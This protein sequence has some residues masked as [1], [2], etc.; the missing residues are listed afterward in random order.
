LPTTSG[1]IVTTAGATELTT[2]GNLTFTGPGNRILGDFS[3]ATVANRVMF[4]TSTTNGNT[5]IH[6][7]PNGTGTSSSFEAST[8][9]IGSAASVAQLFSLTTDVRLAANVRDSGTFVPITMHTGGSERLRIDTSGNVGIGTTSTGSYD[10]KFIVS[11]NAALTST[12]NKLYLYYNSATNHANLSTSAGGDITFTTGTSSPTER[13]RI[14]TAGNL[15]VGTTANGGLTGNIVCPAIYN[16]TSANAANMGIDAAFGMFR[17]TSSIKYKTDV[18]DA[19]HGLTELLSLRPVTYKGKND[20]DAVFG[21]LI[22]EE[23]HE[24]GL[25]EFVQ[26]AEDGS[27]DSLAYGHMVS[28]CV[29]AIQELNAKVTALEAQLG[30][31]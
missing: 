1:T 16:R 28:L 20:G 5:N 9:P 13:M 12:G 6:A 24:A 23:V 19:V 29:K 15:L 4:Q 2:S 8:A 30:A 3:N 14:D 21:G 27:P 22:A 18:Q 17:S 11:G 10:S 26:Y 7:I 25:T 31:K